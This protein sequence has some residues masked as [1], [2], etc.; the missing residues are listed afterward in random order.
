[1]NSWNTGCVC[2][3][4]SFLSCYRVLFLVFGW[5]PV[6]RAD[7]WVLL[8]FFTEYFGMFLPSFVVSVE[9]ELGFARLSRVDWAF[10][11]F[12]LVLPSFT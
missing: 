9:D 3:F 6:S 8:G 1:M 11:L 7:L 5:S 2:D 10:T 4:F 12:Y